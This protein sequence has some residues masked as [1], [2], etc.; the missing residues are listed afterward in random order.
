MAIT[1]KAVRRVRPRPPRLPTSGTLG[2]P[3][4][5]LEL[6]FNLSSYLYSERVSAHSASFL[7]N[8]ACLETRFWLRLDGLVGKNRGAGAFKQ[9]PTP[10]PRS[11]L[12]VSAGGSG[13]AAVVCR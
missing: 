12:A 8:D 9:D 2:L 7:K 10:A 3:V 4:G 13:R 1:K 11:E 6:M 5:L